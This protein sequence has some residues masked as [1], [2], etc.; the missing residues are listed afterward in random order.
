VFLHRAHAEMQLLH[1]LSRGGAWVVGEVLCNP[2]AVLANGPTSG[3]M[4]ELD[5]V[6]VSD[7]VHARSGTSEFFCK[8]GCE[9]ALTR[10]RKQSL[11][12]Y[13]IPRSAN[14]FGLRLLSAS[15]ASAALRGLSELAAYLP[16]PGWR[17]SDILRNVRG[18]SVRI[19]F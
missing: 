16:H 9:N 10:S 7:T 4:R 3:C 6:R 17:K 11:F 19:S 13:S 14:L 15:G 18:D 12:V 8:V 5:A 2:V 1:H